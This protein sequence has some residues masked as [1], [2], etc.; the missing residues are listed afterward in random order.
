MKKKII[1]IIDILF[2]GYILFSSFNEPGINIDISE[3]INT[4]FSKINFLD[5]NNIL[6][7]FNLI[8]GFI[9]VAIFLIFIGM[10]KNLFLVILYI[11]IRFGFSHAYK[12]K[13]NKDDVKSESYYREIIDK[14]SIA[15]LSYIDDFKIDNKDIIA[16]ILSLKLK[17]KIVIEDDIKVVNDDASELEEN[18]K[19]ILEC[20]K[21]KK[22]I[23][24]SKFK[25]LVQKD[26]INK[27]LLKIQFAIFNRKYVITYIII[28]FLL[29]LINII[30]FLLP[31]DILNH[32]P[33][34]L[35]ILFFLGGLFAFLFMPFI[36]VVYVF[37]KGI[38]N[39]INP[40]VRTKLGVEINKNIEGLKNYIKD[41]SNLENKKVK[42]IELWD[43]YLIYSVMFNENKN[44]ISELEDKIK[45]NNK[46]NVS[47]EV[48]K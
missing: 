20:L 3:L 11:G 5:F 37:F 41:F 23:D 2:W 33:A 43:E 36:G 12:E 40:F 30:M 48:E 28:A 38:F 1:R 19:Y 39:A 26:C 18:E 10:L 14:Y 8:I 25:E 29:I 16:T 13:F 9:F 42:E 46:I 27:Q 24:F 45:I 34:W 6:L 17:E 4:D 35:A 7:F 21:E 31:N 44:V 47:V 22:E 32:I 15:S